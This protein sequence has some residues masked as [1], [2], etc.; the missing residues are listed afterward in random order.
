MPTDINSSPQLTQA[1]LDF[2]ASSSAALPDEMKSQYAEIISKPVQFEQMMDLTEFFYAHLD[3]IDDSAR[4]L[5]AGIALFAWRNNFM[6]FRA[7]NDRGLKI[8]NACYRE[9]GLD[10][11]DH[12]PSEDPEPAPR[13]SN[14][15]AEPV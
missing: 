1:I 9:M 15:A 13:F 6:S 3:D 10:G 7:D 2:H 4:D 5:C 12:D 14:T 8:A 11:F